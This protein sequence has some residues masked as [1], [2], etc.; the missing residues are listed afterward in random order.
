MP[1]LAGTAIDRA[2]LID[3]DT[4]TAGGLPLQFPDDVAPPDAA[5]IA[6]LAA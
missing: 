1:R 5:A 2:T 6:W 4:Y 3:L